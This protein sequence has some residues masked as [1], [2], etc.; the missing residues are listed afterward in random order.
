MKKLITNKA[1]SIKALLQNIAKSSGKTFNEI[2]QIYGTERFLYRLSKSTENK[3][4]TLKG[5]T[6]FRIWAP[7]TAR[8]NKHSEFLYED[9]IELTYFAE[10]KLKKAS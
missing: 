4:F 6:M 8:P 10:F 2:L 7:E 1:A 5:G 3:F 9:V